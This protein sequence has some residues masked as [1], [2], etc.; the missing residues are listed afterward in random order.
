MYL[1]S[2]SLYVFMFFPS[3]CSC[4]ELNENFHFHFPLTAAS[5]KPVSLVR[6]MTPEEMRLAPDAAVAELAS[7]GYRSDEVVAA[8]R[9]SGG[10]P[11]GAFLKLYSRLTGEIFMTQNGSQMWL[12]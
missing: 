10:I 8:L 6:A 1:F 4:L 9:E 12:V 3:C 5:A 2:K 11:E 7:C